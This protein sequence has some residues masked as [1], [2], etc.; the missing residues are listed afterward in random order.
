MINH[1]GHGC[2]IVAPL[3]LRASDRLLEDPVWVIHC[4]ASLLPGSFATQS[5]EDVRSEQHN[6]SGWLA[7]R[8][9]LDVS[10]ASEAA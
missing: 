3:L 9:E 8:A 2:A 4:R 6:V 5:K 1:R 7:K 10:T